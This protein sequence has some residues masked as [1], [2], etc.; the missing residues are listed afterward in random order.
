M[1]TPTLPSALSR[2]V[3]LAMAAKHNLY[4]SLNTDKSGKNQE[5]VCTPQVTLGLYG[6]ASRAISIG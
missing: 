5:S 2:W 4:V 6:Q 1:G 3:Q